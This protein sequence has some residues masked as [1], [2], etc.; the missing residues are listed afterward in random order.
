MEIT[1]KTPPS[2]SIL[3]PPVWPRFG[4]LKQIIAS[5]STEVGRLM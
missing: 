1:T 5:A 3:P 2:Q 4:I